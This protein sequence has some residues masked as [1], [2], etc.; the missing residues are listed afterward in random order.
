MAGDLTASVG[1]RIED[2][3]TSARQAAEA[4]QREVE[5]ASAR[6]ATEVRLEAEE[7]ARRIR[8]AAE[9]EAQRHLEDARRRVQAFADARVRR[10]AELTD[11][12][13]AAADGLPAQL[14]GALAVRRQVD[15]LIA[16]LGTAAEQAAR[17]AARPAI[18]LPSIDETRAPGETHQQGDA[19]E[20][21]RA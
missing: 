21:A 11:E 1:A 7:D 20:A 14:D 15:D 3:M 6:R 18:K 2:I 13:V 8:A 5:E 16:A 10:I 4:L 9:A 12:L 17:E 19:D